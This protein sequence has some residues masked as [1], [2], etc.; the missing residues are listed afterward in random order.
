MDGGSLIGTPV[1]VEVPQTYTRLVP[2]SPEELGLEIVDW[3]D[4]EVGDGR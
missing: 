3:P 4:E 1:T 2:C